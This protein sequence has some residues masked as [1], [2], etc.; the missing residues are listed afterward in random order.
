MKILLLYG[1]KKL[2][3]IYLDV[4]DSIKTNYLICENL[5]INC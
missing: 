5:K 3:F 1:R 2:F 4:C